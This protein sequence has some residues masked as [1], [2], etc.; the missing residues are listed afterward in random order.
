MTSM[1]ESDIDQFI[2]NQ[3]AKLQQ[4][5]QQLADDERGERVGRRQWDDPGK[6]TQY[7]EQLLPKRTIM[8]RSHTL[9]DPKSMK[10][11][12]YKDARK[13]L[14]KERRKDY[15]EYLRTYHHDL[16]PL[17]S[18]SSYSSPQTRR[19]N[20]RHSPSLHYPML[21]QFSFDQ[22]RDKSSE[23]TNESPRKPEVDYKEWELSFQKEKQRDYNQYLEQ[24]KRRTRK[25]PTPPGSGLKFG[26]FEEYRKKIDRQRKQ[27]YKEE[28]EKQQTEQMMLKAQ[29]DYNTVPFIQTSPRFDPSKEKLDHEISDRIMN[30]KFKEF[31]KMMALNKTH[32]QHVHVDKRRTERPPA[33]TQ[34][35]VVPEEKTPDKPSEPNHYYD[36]FHYQK[37]QQQL[38]DERQKETRQ[39]F[40]QR[41]DPQTNR[42]NGP[43]KEEA[44]GLQ[45]GKYE[46][47][48]KK[49]EQE[50][51]REYNEMLAKQAQR[52][53]RSKG[54]QLREER[55]QPQ[56]QREERSFARPQPN[57]PDESPITQPRDTAR[58]SFEQYDR[59]RQLQEDKENEYYD[60]VS[61][62]QH[63]REDNSVERLPQGRQ[64]SYTEGE[65]AALTMLEEKEREYQQ[66]LNELQVER[67]DSEEQNKPL[68]RPGNSDDTEA[69]DRKLLNGS[70]P[71]YLLSESHMDEVEKKIEKLKKYLKERNETAYHTAESLLGEI[72]DQLEHVQ[73]LLS[74]SWLIP[75]PIQR[76]YLKLLKIYKHQ[77]KK[78]YSREFSSERQE[79]ERETHREQLPPK[80][81]T[82]GGM[83]NK[84]GAHDRQRDKLN[85]E[86]KE[87]YN[88]L[89]NEGDQRG[90]GRRSEPREAYQP[91]ARQQP[92]PRQRPST[93]EAPGASLKGLNP[94]DSAEQRKKQLRND[95][96]N[97]FLRQKGGRGRGRQ[98][99]GRPPLPTSARNPRHGYNDTEPQN[100][101]VNSAT[102]ER[103]VGKKDDIFATLPGL[104]YSDSAEKRKMAV[105]NREYNEMLQNK[106]GKRR[107]RSN[108]NGPPGPRTGWQSPSY[109][110][111][112]DR[113]RQEKA[114]YRRDDPTGMRAYNSEGAIDTLGNDRYKDL[115]REYETRKVRFRDQ[116]SNILDNDQWLDSDQVRR[117]V[118]YQ[119]LL[120]KVQ[121]SQES[122]QPQAAPRGPPP[123]E[124]PS[125]S[126][127]A[128]S[129]YATLPVGTD[130][131]GNERDSAKR[132]KQSKYREE[133]QLQMQEA[134]AAKRR[135]KNLEKVEDLR[136]NAS[137][138][139]D[140]EKTVR[141]IG[142]LGNPDISPRRQMRSPEV[143]PY[144][145]KFDLSPRGGR[146]GQDLNLDLGGV[147]GYTPR[148]RGRP[149]RR[150]RGAGGGGGS[151]GGLLDTGF[152]GLLES[153]PRGAYAPPGIQYQPSTYI[154]GGGGLNNPA[155]SSI[156]EAYHFYGM[157]NP[158]DPEPSGGGGGPDIPL[159]RLDDQPYSR[160][161]SPPRVTFEDN[162]RARSRSKER[163]S[164][165]QFPSD[166]D[167]RSKS[168][169]DQRAYQEELQRQIQE[170]KYREQK[171]KED[172]DRYERKLDEEIR[173]YNPFGRGGGGAPIKD[174]AGNAV[175]DL[176]SMHYENVGG[177]SARSPPPRESP[178]F[179]APASPKDDLIKPPPMQQNAKGENT[180]A[181]G[182]HGI[183][184]QP[185][186]DAE[187]D[188]ADKY[189]DDLRRQIEEKKRY[190]QIEREKE[191][192]EEEKENRRLEEQR[193]RIQQEYEEEVRK[194][195]E[196]EEDARR[197]NEELRKQAEDRKNEESRKRR[198]DADARSREKQEQEDRERT[199]RQREE[200]GGSPPIPA[201]RS[202]LATE[203]GEPSEEKRAVTKPPPKSKEPLPPKKTNYKPD[204]FKLS[205]IKR[206]SAP[207][208]HGY[209]HFRTS[210]VSLEPPTTQTRITPEIKTSTSDGRG[211]SPPVPSHRS[212]P[213]PQVAPAPLQLSRANS[214]D[215]LKELATMRKQLQSERKRV[216]NALENQKNEP[217][218]FDPR[219]VQRPPPRE[220]DVFERAKQGHAAVPQRQSDTANA[221]TLQEFNELKYKTDTDSRR[222]FRSMFP[223][224][225]TSNSALESQ[226]DALLRHQEDT[227]KNLKD[228][229]YASAVRHSIEEELDYGTGRQ[230]TMSPKS[231]LNSNSAFI[232]VDT[233]NHFPEDFEDLPKRN[234]SARMRR[235]ERLPLSP[236]P[237]SISL[238]PMGSTTSLDVDRIQKKNDARLRRLHQ[239]NTDDVSIA[240]PD[241]ILDRFMAKQRYNRPPSGQTLQ[242]DSWLRPGSKAF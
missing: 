167:F 71:L 33:R 69:G 57:Y 4:E 238:N 129:Y 53:K 200:R 31:D 43:P 192:I 99:E 36:T 68:P 54:A 215:V 101:R 51:K 66:L 67:N 97:E 42:T 104:H 91:E 209:D 133:L 188:T 11:F 185:R 206:D 39:F 234:D 224:A 203:N 72:G 196:K 63:G 231:M 93:D 186:T 218:V 241:D 28:L 52:G 156:D 62:L 35:K 174:T 77:L 177:T 79:K 140:P 50:R 61:K 139:L 46:E 65:T 81:P 226:Q 85:E 47:K 55:S 60:L 194:K 20:R 115:D 136:V 112:L 175:T 214:S 110:D 178:R 92:E 75:M 141:R 160:R 80:P 87:E 78:M 236:R 122:Q 187:K 172:K 5:R 153:R 109:D 195:R 96:Y 210:S 145:T 212:K 219:M 146:N 127:M 1:M 227:L 73:T 193:I 201:I 7:A 45:L 64:S 134:V 176:R 16:I 124:E 123:R 89:I 40:E 137:G 117:D 223:D 126:E 169:Q 158:L 56:T 86:R 116:R 183:F 114:K 191:K 205:I 159:N 82:P 128:T 118:E 23:K 100:R 106:D 21:P 74:P 242:D 119:D 15:E 76:R 171:E 103:D 207:N 165:Y 13:E 58:S 138:F 18:S 120:N 189:K 152:E 180:Y 240:D 164:P 88:R 125:S 220:I 225:P 94:R 34:D 83:F 22:F 184:G 198:E 9:P 90:R 222:A 8:V 211:R 95:E 204:D 163:I 2:Q 32:E 155:L 161:M 49:L 135:N 29:R 154:T 235:R 12:D 108:E 84:L 232:D 221:R 213:E 24:K 37:H 26:E 170:K 14:M 102:N 162:T 142:N 48:R 144:H 157:K 181:R 132:R 107:G 166:D 228:R 190:D 202:K 147:G 25:Q 59:S 150:G 216:E 173:N 149:Q 131:G 44:P 239:M 105:R 208:I 229:R 6:E 41:A 237:E 113:K 148:E 151:G 30:Q 143:Q 27:D 19:Y 197:K 182:G 130:R 230:G 217:D 98:T 111:V 17:L 233:V 121:S 199:E 70:P 38:K 168:R 10:E 179:R 3:K